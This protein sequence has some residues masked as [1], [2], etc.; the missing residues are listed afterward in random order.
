MSETE[1][2]MITSDLPPKPE[3]ENKPNTIRDIVIA[4]ILGALLFLVFQFFFQFYQ[5]SGPSMNNTLFNEQRVLVLK[6]SK[7]PSRGD[8]IIFHPPNNPSDLYIKR[9]IGLPG[10][11]ISIQNGIVYVNNLALHEPYAIAIT[12]VNMAAVLVG[13]REYFVL[14]DNR[15]VSQD[16]RS[17]GCIPQ[18]NIIGKALFIF[19]PVSDWGN[20]VTYKP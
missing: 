11:V 4:I 19:L 7:N 18:S 8:V 5:V 10:D 6:T 17:I 3:S 2:S 20:R 9:V 16:S 14:G 1:V 12:G 13:E 15:P